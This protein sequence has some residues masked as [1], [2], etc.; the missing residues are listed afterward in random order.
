MEN[1]DFIRVFINLS[2][3]IIGVIITIISMIVTYKIFDHIL[4]FNMN[5]ELDEGNVAIGLVVAGIFISIGLAIGLSIG[6]A[7]N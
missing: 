1:F 4:P 5:T 6:Y 2:Y 7:L 3:A